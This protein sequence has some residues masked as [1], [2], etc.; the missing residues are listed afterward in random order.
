MMALQR[1]TSGMLQ[2]S[3]GTPAFLQVGAISSTEGW[4]G[5]STVGDDHRMEP[6][7]SWAYRARG[8]D[9]LVEVRVVR[10]GTQKPARVLA[11]FVSDEFEGKEEWVPPARLKVLWSQA[12]EFRAR[13]ER[14]ARMCAVGPG[15]EDPRDYAASEIFDEYVDNELATINYRRGASITIKQKEALAERLGLRVEQLTDHPEAFT[16]DGAVVAPW[17]ATELVARTVAEQNAEKVLQRVEAEER[18]AR[19]AA[20]HGEHPSRGRRDDY[21]SPEISEE[22]D[23]DYG[24][25]VRDVLRSWCGAENVERFDELVELRKEIKRVGDVAQSAIDAL[26]AYGHPALASRFE[27]ELGTPVEMLRADQPHG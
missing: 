10:Q 3:G 21:I 22:V 11:R 7:E 4:L 17:L 15:Q 2:S 16:E 12:A 13:E 14:W 27:R 1:L 19:Y 18:Q 25:P 9:P 8:V 23:R 26:R 6:G 20:I 5:W 24:R